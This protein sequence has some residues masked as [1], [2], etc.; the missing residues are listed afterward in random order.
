MDCPPLGAKAR[1]R[2][3]ESEGRSRVNRLDGP[4]AGDPTVGENSQNSLASRYYSN[5][6]NP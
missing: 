5:I 1:G 3:L 4:T 2:T 6:L